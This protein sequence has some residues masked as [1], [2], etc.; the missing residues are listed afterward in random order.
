VVATGNHYPLDLVAGAVLVAICIPVTRPWPP[1][2]RQRFAQ[3]LG[4]LGAAL[5]RRAVL[6]DGG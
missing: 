1:A 5:R 4:P 3:R 6:T 2:A